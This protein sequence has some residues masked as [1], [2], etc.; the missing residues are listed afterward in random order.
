MDFIPYGLVILLA[1]LVA[2]AILLFVFCRR[3]RRRKTDA[4]LPVRVPDVEIGATTV[5]TK[6]SDGKKQWLV[7]NP[8]TLSHGTEGQRPI[9]GEPKDPKPD[10]RT[11]E[12]LPDQQGVKV[13]GK[14]AEK[15]PEVESVRGPGK[16]S[17]QVPDQVPAPVHGYVGPRVVSVVPGRV[18]DQV[19]ERVQN[20]VPKVPNLNERVLMP[21]VRPQPSSVTPSRDPGDGFGFGFSQHYMC[22]C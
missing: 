4:P 17:R 3:C 15:V 18:Q 14:V 7:L 11:R 6:T 21:T 1:C 20:K 2:A 19:G 8:S 22:Y 9:V 5:V 12:P 10:F 16:A 13:S